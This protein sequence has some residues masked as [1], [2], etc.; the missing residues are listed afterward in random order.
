VLGTRGTRI[1][2]LSPAFAATTS[3]PPPTPPPSPPFGT[4]C[5]RTTHA[6][7]PPSRGALRPR[8]ATHGHDAGRAGSLFAKEASTARN[9]ASHADS[10]GAAGGAAGDARDERVEHL[11]LGVRRG[12]G[13]DVAVE[14]GVARQEVGDRRASVRAVAA[15][16]SP[17]LA[18]ARG[19]APGHLRG[20]DERVLAL[21]RGHLHGVRAR[22]GD[23]AAA[24]TREPADDGRHRAPVRRGHDLDRRHEGDR[25]GA[26]RGPGVAST[27]RRTPH[28]PAR[29]IYDTTTTTAAREAD[30]AA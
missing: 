24:P 3:T 4:R 25:D 11:A 17:T 10:R 13:V 1:A 18:P 20:R 6:V 21:E 22:A 16:G 9:A 23:L 26:A 12:V 2:P 19:R 27:R 15:A 8:H 30:S 14:H 7:V 28:P 5:A 29:E